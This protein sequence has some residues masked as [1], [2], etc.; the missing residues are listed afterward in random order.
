MLSSPA[1]DEGRTALEIC[2]KGIDLAELSSIL[3]QGGMQGLVAGAVVYATHRLGRRLSN[4]EWGRELATRRRERR[5]NTP[6]LAIV[7]KHEPPL[8]RL[9]GRVNQM[10]QD[11]GP[12]FDFHIRIENRNKFAQ[13]RQV[14]AVLEAMWEYDATNTPNPVEDFLSIKFRYDSEG[15]KYEEINP[16]RHII[17]NLGYLPNPD[18][19]RERL[20]VPMYVDVAEATGDVHRFY[21]DVGDFP[22]HQPNRFV[23]GKYGI[24][25]SV[26]AENAERVDQHFEITWTG[27]WRD[28]IQD[29]VDEIRIEPVGRIQ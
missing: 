2:V 25:V 27:T 3:V 18:V 4:I 26:Y 24:L 22:F 29:I 1:A 5:R 20:Q 11:M 9:S 16:E 12:F 8:A 19:Q 28:D 23:P 7:Y 21:L 10:G 14:E 13:A 15:T 6:E 17:W